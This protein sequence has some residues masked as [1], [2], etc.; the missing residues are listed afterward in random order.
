M[1]HAIAGMPM[2]QNMRLLGSRSMSAPP[3]RM[4]T[5]PISPRVGPMMFATSL[6]ER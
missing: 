1:K 4:P 3:T 6:T 2:R 5:I